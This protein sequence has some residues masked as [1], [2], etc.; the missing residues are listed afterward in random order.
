MGRTTSWVLGLKTSAERTIQKHTEHAR[1]K[2]YSSKNTI[3]SL[4]HSVKT[5][6]SCSF[7]PFQIFTF[8]DVSKQTRATPMPNMFV[9]T[10]WHSSFTDSDRFA[11]IFNDFLK[12][13]RCPGHVPDLP[14]LLRLPFPKMWD[15]RSCRAMS[16]RHDVCDGDSVAAFAAECQ[17]ECHASDTE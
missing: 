7:Q 5:C 2:C 16:S 9:F 1:L 6:S 15:S 3:W 8:L 4:C 10:I 12:G 11:T 17:T 13:F 14:G